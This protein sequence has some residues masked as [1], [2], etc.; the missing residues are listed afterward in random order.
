MAPVLLFCF[1]VLVINDYWMYRSYI[2]ECWSIVAAA[3][4]MR[5]LR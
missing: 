4:E 1:S 3:K 2:L 5:F